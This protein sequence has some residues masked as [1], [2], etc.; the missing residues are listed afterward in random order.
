M[1]YSDKETGATAHTYGSVLWLPGTSGSTDLKQDFD[2]WPKKAYGAIGHRGAW[3]QANYLLNVIDW[4][5]IKIIKGHSLGGAV[6]L[7]LGLM[8]G[9]EVETYGCFKVFLWTSRNKPKAVNYRF[10]SDPVSWLFW[11]IRRNYGKNKLLFKWPG[12]N[13]HNAYPQLS[14]F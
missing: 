7:W 9:I 11:P 12:F 10:L 3:E 6:A 14:E 2:F 4:E 8:T 1:K 5:D 13:D